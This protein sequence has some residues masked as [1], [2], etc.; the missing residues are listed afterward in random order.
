MATVER[1]SAVRVW[2]GFQAQRKQL[3]DL[4]NNDKEQ[5]ETCNKEP[6]S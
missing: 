5:I 6:R 4:L 2:G 3:D 1:G